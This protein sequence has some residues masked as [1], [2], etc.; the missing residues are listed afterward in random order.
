M[1][2]YKKIFAVIIFL[3]ILFAVAELSGLRGH[4]NVAF[5][6]QKLADNIW[7]GLS[8]FVLLFV[9]GNLI[10]I[11]GWI[12]LAAAV[13]TLGKTW[14]G[15][16]TY[17][18]A[19]VSC[20]CTFVAIRYIGGDALRRLDGKLAT[21]ILAQLDARPILSIA[22]LRILFQTLPALNYSLA[23]SGVGFRRYMIG[24]AV[25]LPLPLLAY[26]VLFDSLVTVFVKHA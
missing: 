21:R 24:T 17:V 1:N 18:A 25:G 26:C 5:V 19:N 7:S 23:L 20:A 4:F 13:L 22:T 11:P 2:S 10:Q 15:I 16:A 8:I 6:R 14:G 12:V 3:L 9:I